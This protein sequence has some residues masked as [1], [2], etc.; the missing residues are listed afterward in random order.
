MPAGSQ[1]ITNNDLA[2]IFD[3][4]ARLLEIKG[5]VVFKIRAY[6]RAAESLRALSESAAR[7][8]AED[9]LDEI[10]GVGS[11]IADKI[12]EILK[13]GHLGFLDKLEAEVPPTLLELLRVPDLGPRKAALF[14][15]Q[16]GVTDLASLEAAARAGKL[17]DL[18]G[19][20]EKSESRVIA[21]IEA[22]SR[23]GNRMTLEAAGEHARH[24]LEWL[25][26]QPGVEHAEPAGSLR[27]W[28]ETVGDLDLVA[29]T[30][31]TESLLDTFVNQPEVERILGQGDNKASVE[32]KNGVRI[33]LWASV[34]ER[35]GSLL[36]YATGSKAH[37]VR[38]RE[39]ALKKK[40]SLSDRG[41]LTQ[42]DQ[43]IT[44]A[45]EA[46]VYR[47]LGLPWIPPELR[48]DRGE[49]EAAQKS[50]LP[51]LIEV[52]DIKA[53]FHAHTTWSD[54]ALSIE[55][56]ARAAMQ[57]GLTL[58]AITDHSAYLGVT[59]GLTAETL[60]KQREEIQ[61]VRQKL[62]DSFTLLHGI[63]VDITADGHLALPDEALASLDV[64]I[65]S[66]H[67]SLRQPRETVTNRLLTAIR[68]PHVDIIA[69][70]SGRLLPGR[71]CADLDWDAIFTAAQEA[72]I[73]LEINASAS[74]LDLNDVHARRA[75]EMGIPLAINTDAHSP[76]DFETVIYGV[77][78]ARR[79]WVSS[80]AVMNTWSRQ[81]IT[82]WLKS[83]EKSR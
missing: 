5:E 27:R 82:S 4:I 65:A 49:I 47:A 2:D 73:A 51:D 67:I 20:G 32:L 24:W 17:R 30:S 50:R 42:D 56:M 1:S 21:G 15:K 57:R 31:D 78:T 79:G 29:A 36:A 40:L 66:L 80:P 13:T 6:E 8:A 68:N 53:E 74:R 75:V 28:R 54:G 3:R 7:L 46:D 63:E 77:E 16:L 33:Q 41:M 70:P 25:R 39:L 71:E 61:R 38:M 44:Y 34:P 10:P 37:N 64:V 59:G 22:L 55:Q 76:H 60:P 23:L 26:A 14:W 12:Q 62:G 43:L 11:A 9:R 19:M 45:E 52:G 58:L 69:H 81:K 83:R 35:F 48:E 18:P 72:G